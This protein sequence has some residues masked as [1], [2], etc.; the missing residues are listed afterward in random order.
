MNGIKIV[1]KRASQRVEFFRIRLNDQFVP[2][3]AFAP[4]GDQNAI[5]AVVVDL[6]SEGVQ[7]LTN[8][9]NRIAT[10]F[11]QFE[12]SGDNLNENVQTK[13]WPVRHIWSRVQG[14]YLLS[15]FSFSGK[16]SIPSSVIAQLNR[17]TPRL[18]PCLLSP[19]PNCERSSETGSF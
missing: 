14:M 5:A 17:A 12:L 13:S 15:G 11:H 6:T 19:I 4:D 9:E 8:P 18:L 16:M 1:E 3:F 10:P 7:V 2:M